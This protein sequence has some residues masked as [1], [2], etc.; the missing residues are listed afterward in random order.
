MKKPHPLASVSKRG[1]PMHCQRV[2]RK[3]KK[4]EGGVSQS[5]GT[6]QS[7]VRGKALAHPRAMWRRGCVPKC[8][9]KGRGQLCVTEEVMG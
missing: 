9:A 8:G 4:K 6:S 5:E 3:K 1:S 2:S 7:E